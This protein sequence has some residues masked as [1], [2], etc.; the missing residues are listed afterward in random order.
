MD[1]FPDRRREAANSIDNGQIGL[2]D[3]RAPGAISA[4]IGPG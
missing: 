1:E 4:G 2:P 3:G